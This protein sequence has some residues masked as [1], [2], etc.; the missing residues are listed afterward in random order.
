MDRVAEAAAEAHAPEDPQRVVGERG[1]RVHRR[2]DDAVAQVR[3]AMLRPVLNRSGVHVV[4][5]GIHGHVTAH[6]ILERRAER[7]DG[8]AVRALVHLLAQVDKVEVKA[9]DARR[10]RLEVLALL[11]IRRDLANVADPRMTRRRLLHLARQGRAGKHLALQVRLEEQR[12]VVARHRRQRHVQIMR[13]KAQQLVPHPATR[14]ARLTRRRGRRPVAQIRVRAGRA[15]DI[16]TR[17]RRLHP[18]ARIVQQRAQ[19][20]L[21]ARQRHT[22]WHSEA[23]QGRPHTWWWRL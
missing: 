18:A 23:P 21:L 3:E 6:R 2:A 13:R 9:E 15:I 14:N 17:I 19:E 11:G 16:H 10:R 4:E 8:Y 1:R 22:R 7:H 20:P 12:K 5:E